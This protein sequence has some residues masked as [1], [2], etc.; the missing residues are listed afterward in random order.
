MQYLL[1]RTSA[2]QGGKEKNG[3]DIFLVR[4]VTLDKWRRTSWRVGMSHVVCA[5]CRLGSWVVVVVML[6]LMLMLM[7][8][9]SRMLCLNV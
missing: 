1:K 8:S 6:M 5:L 2:G 9:G 3:W 4:W 7:R